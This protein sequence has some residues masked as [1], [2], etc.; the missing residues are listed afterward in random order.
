VF[1]MRRTEMGR[2]EGQVDMGLSETILGPPALVTGR[3][4]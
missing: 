4:K 1:S 3:H 2:G